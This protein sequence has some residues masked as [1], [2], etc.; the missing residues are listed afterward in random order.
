MD[1]GR[2]PRALFVDLDGTVRETLSGR[3]HPVEPWDQRLRPNVADRLA[4]YRARGY[5][6][7][8][9]TNQGGVAFGTLSEDDVRAINDHLRTELAPGLFDLILYCPYHPYGTVA[10]YRRG[11]PCR[12]PSPGMAYEARD[13][14]GLDLRSSIMVGDSEADRLFARNAGIGHFYWEDDFFGPTAAAS[15]EADA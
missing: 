1:D 4:E 5:H 14:Y 11:A 2:R 15:D 9:A 6:I 12:K 7:I 13:R 3:V 8:G 10:A